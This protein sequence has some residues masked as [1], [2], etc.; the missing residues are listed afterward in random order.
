MLGERAGLPKG[1]LSIVTSSRSS[2]IGK[3]F[4]ENPLIRK[5]TF[6]G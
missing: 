4:C 2:D 6:T 1:I 5:L 3:E